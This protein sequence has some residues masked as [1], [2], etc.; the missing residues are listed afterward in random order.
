MKAARAGQHPNKKNTMA[1]SRFWEDPMITIWEA[2]DD[3]VAGLPWPEWLRRERE[4][5][6]SHGKPA[7]I[8][9]MENRRG[10]VMYAL[11]RRPQEETVLSERHD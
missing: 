2:E 1:K 3:I 5:I 10:K 6:L 7:H 4:R 11:S 9:R 8:V